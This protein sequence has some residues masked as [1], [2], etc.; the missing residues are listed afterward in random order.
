[1]ACCHG[2]RRALV[3]ELHASLWVCPS[4]MLE[5]FP[6]GVKGHEDALL[7]AHARAVLCVPSVE[8]RA[9]ARVREEQGYAVAIERCAELVEE[10]LGFDP[11]VAK[12]TERREGDF[13]G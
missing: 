5:I 3:Y 10:R 6:V 9:V 8:R 12:P 11:R 1:M 13:N 2:W 7:T 4:C